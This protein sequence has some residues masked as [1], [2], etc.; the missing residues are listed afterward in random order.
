MR[1]ADKGGGAGDGV[2][3]TGGGDGVPA[4]LP[5]L[6]IAFAQKTIDIL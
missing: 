3:G 1:P 6:Q 2:G 4:T 5:N